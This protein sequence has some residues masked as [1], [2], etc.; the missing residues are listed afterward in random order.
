VTTLRNRAYYFLKPYL[1][2]RL[3]TALR[4]VQVQRVRAA[5]GDVWPINP[6]AAQPPAGWSGWPGGKQFAV[7]LTHDVE[8]HRG[9]ERCGALAKVEST[10]GFRSSFNFIPEGEYRVAPE[11]RQALVN[12]G[13]EVGVHDL[14]H[15][16]KLY[17]TRQAFV[18]KARRINQ[19]LEDWGA[20]GFRSGFMLRNL[21]WIRDLDIEYDASTFDTDPFEPQPDGVT[22]IFP[23]FIDGAR[24][25]P[26]YVELPYTLVQDS[27]LFLLLRE[28]DFTLWKKKADWIAERGGMVLLNVHP[29]YLQFPDD[30]P[31]ATTFAVQHYVDFLKYLN[32]VYS[33]RFW[34]PLPR[35]MAAWYR[36]THGCPAAPTGTNRPAVRER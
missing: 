5:S 22:T 3:R 28:P 4:R 24:G 35:E 18:E 23:L 7:V 31:L 32:D 11:L 2:K 1:P 17:Q 9:V 25:R 36:G 34:A 21:D 29:D 10:L 26:G 13:F 19:Y 6:A 27:T 20:V 8:G 16:G 14:H 15:D 12:Q 30:R 33:D